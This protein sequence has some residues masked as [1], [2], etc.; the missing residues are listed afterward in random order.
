MPEDIENEMRALWVLCQFR[1]RNSAESAHEAFHRFKD[2]KINGQFDLV[3]KIYEDEN[4]DSLVEI[5]V[6]SKPEYPIWMGYK[7]M[8]GLFRA[9]KYQNELGRKIN[10]LVYVWGTP[11]QTLFARVLEN[12]FL[13]FIGKTPPMKSKP[14]DYTKGK[15]GEKEYLYGVPEDLVHKINH[16]T[17]PKPPW[18][19]EGLKW[20]D[21]WVEHYL[22]F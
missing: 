21:Q 22:P 20:A 10:E 13:N 6:R 9:M 18:N 14:S 11:D 3:D 7:K 8:A 1:H 19:N 4:H 15:Y 16:S 12:D 2:F 5:R 17:L